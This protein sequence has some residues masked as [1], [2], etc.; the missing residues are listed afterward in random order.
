[1]ISPET[2]AHLILFVGAIAFAVLAISFL[3]D[4]TF[5]FVWLAEIESRLWGLEQHLDRLTDVP[6]EDIDAERTL[7]VDTVLC[8]QALNVQIAAIHVLLYINAYHDGL[9]AEPTHVELQWI[10]LY[11][12]K[13]LMSAV[14]VNSPVSWWIANALFLKPNSLM[15]QFARHKP[16]NFILKACA[17]RS[18][19]PEYRK[20]AKNIL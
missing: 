8:A 14:K 7:I 5:R 19:Q 11:R 13:L 16:S 12:I 17:M 10:D 1:M 4:H 18:M 2:G 15:E 6:K 3:Y 20:I 9:L